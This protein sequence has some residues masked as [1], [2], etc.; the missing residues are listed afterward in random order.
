MVRYCLLRPRVMCTSAT[1]KV[2]MHNLPCLACSDSISIAPVHF[3]SAAGQFPHENGFVDV[4]KA[5]DTRQPFVLPHHGDAAE[6]V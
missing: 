2:S 6:T 5:D 3:R 1:S 4:A